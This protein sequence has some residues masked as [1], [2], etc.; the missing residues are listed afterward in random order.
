MWPSVGLLGLGDITLSSNV[1]KSLGESRS[2]AFNDPSTRVVDFTLASYSICALFQNGRVRCWGLNNVCSLGQGID[3]YRYIGASN[4]DMTNLPYISFGGTEMVSNI[5]G[6]SQI[7][8]LIIFSKGPFNIVQ[9]DGCLC[10]FFFW[11]CK[12][13]GI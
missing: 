3:N 12:M 9:W 1:P 5:S 10:D 4:S 11:R 8:E 2:I 13:L 7:F 6:H